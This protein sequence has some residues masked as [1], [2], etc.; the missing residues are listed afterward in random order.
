MKTFML[1]CLVLCGSAVVLYDELSVVLRGFT[2]IFLLTL[3]WLD[4]AV[5]ESQ[6]VL[7]EL[8]NGP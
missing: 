7:K 6:H 8:H 2:L 4:G 3:V 5:R 1:C